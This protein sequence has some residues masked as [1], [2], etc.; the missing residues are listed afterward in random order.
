[1]DVFHYFLHLD[2]KKLGAV[3]FLLFFLSVVLK[4]LVELII[5][6][7]TWAIFLKFLNIKHDLSSFYVSFI[8]LIGLIA[9]IIKCITLLVSVTV[10]IYTILVIS[11]AAF[12]YYTQDGYTNLISLARFIYFVSNRAADKFKTW[13]SCDLQKALVSLYNGANHENTLQDQF[14]GHDKKLIERIL[15][16][17]VEKSSKSSITF[18]DIVGQGAAKQALRDAIVLPTLYPDHF[19]SLLSPEKGILLFGP[20]GNAKTLLAKAAADECGATF[21]AITA[22]NLQLTVTSKSMGEGEKLVKALFAVAKKRQPS[23]IFIDEIDSIF[24]ARE[25]TEHEASRRLKT[26]FLIEMDGLKNDS[27]DRL[28]IVGAT[29][30]PQELDDAIW[31]RFSKKIYVDIPNFNDRLT[32][33]KNLLASQ[34]NNL[35][36]SHFRNIASWTERYS[37]RDLT[38]LAK[39]AARCCLRELPEEQLKS[40]NRNSIRGI[41]LNDFVLALKSIHATLTP[42]PLD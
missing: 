8:I 39:E 12:L 42:Q 10:I 40:I 22:E 16:N 26:E 13:L 27:T 9:V 24:T 35:S 34:T 11:A 20:P 1:M 32:L 7:P 3:I 37:G 25:D 5:E 4:C 29:N 6:T 21:L 2:D 36:E 23:I 38:E 31:S 28:T 30:R 18:E 15:L 17:I 41:T 33:L 19:Q 14:P